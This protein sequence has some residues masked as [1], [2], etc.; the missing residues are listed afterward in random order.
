MMRCMASL[1]EGHPGRSSHIGTREAHQ[2]RLDCYTHSRDHLSRCMDLV[3][4]QSFGHV[5][6]GLE[7]FVD[8]PKL[9]WSLPGVIVSP[10]SDLEKSLTSVRYPYWIVSENASLM[11]GK[12]GVLFEAPANS[13]ER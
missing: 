12:P 7:C 6:S 11:P 8:V 9:T 3:G 13:M 4:Q 1:Q 5:I 10:L 2:H